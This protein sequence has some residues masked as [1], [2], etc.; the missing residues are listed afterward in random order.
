MRPQ[1]KI[2]IARAAHAFA[3][4]KQIQA[5]VLRCMSRMTLHTTAI[6]TLLLSHCCC[7]SVDFLPLLPQCCYSHTTAIFTLH[8]HASSLSF[9]PAA[10]VSHALASYFLRQGAPFLSRCTHSLTL[11]LMFSHEKCRS[12]PRR[13]LR[14]D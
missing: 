6:L 9:S 10:L 7:H 8:A 11:C 3:K 12:Q 2:M 4:L 5:L 13:S 1:Q 14:S